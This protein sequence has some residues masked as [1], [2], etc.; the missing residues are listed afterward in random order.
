MR[1]AFTLVELLVVL[2]IIAV[3]AMMA[4]TFASSAIERARATDCLANLRSLGTAILLHTA[5]HNGSLPRSSHTGGSWHAAIAP[6]LDPPPNLGPATWP[7]FFEARFRCPSDPRTGPATHSYGINVHFELD[8]DID[9]YQGSPATWQR[10]PAIPHPSSTILLAE[11]A[12]SA[13]G[14]HFMC[15]QWSSPAAASNAIAHSR[16]S[17]HP[18]FLFLDGH[19]AP[20]AITNTLDP[21]RSINRWNP[22]LAQP[23]T[24]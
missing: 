11:V 6:H 21:S 14:D 4:S 23:P 15:H 1:K 18:H 5:D 8:P 13:N 3:L 10:L 2:A 12:P 7:A 19:A 17:P 22:S 24:N 9:D 16:H 20:L